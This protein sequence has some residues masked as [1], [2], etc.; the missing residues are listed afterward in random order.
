MRGRW[1]ERLTILG[2]TGLLT[3]CGDDVQNPPVPEPIDEIELFASYITDSF[4]LTSGGETFDVRE[5]GGDVFL[6]LE[7]TGTMSGI[8][9]V[10]DGFF[11]FDEPEVDM[12]GTWSF[13]PTSS[14]VSFEQEADTFIRDTQFVASRDG[15]V[16]L[17]SGVF[18]N[19]DETV[20][21]VLRRVLVAN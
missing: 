19:A 1:S 21:L 16:I 12:A 11:D 18:V 14:A 17:L 5:A 13:D 3:A 15:G 9:V 2:L 8:F 4:E 10:P 6:S 20:R 7:A